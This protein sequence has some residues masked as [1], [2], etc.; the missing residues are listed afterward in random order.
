MASF[1][2]TG[3]LC[4][5]GDVVSNETNRV[6]RELQKIAKAVD[7][8]REE[9]ELSGLPEAC[10]AIRAFAKAAS[11]RHQQPKSRRIGGVAKK[12]PGKQPTGAEKS[13]VPDRNR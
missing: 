6:L 11:P 5:K 13:S 7:F 4:E 2:R 1:H 8:I 9:I 12:S 10:D 3:H